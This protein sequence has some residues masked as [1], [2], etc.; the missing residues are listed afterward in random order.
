LI[1]AAV[2]FLLGG[3]RLFFAPPQDRSLSRRHIFRI[4]RISHKSLLKYQ[5]DHYPSSAACSGAGLGNEAGDSFIESR[6]AI[7]L[8][9]GC[10]TPL[11]CE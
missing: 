11:C 4:G 2:L 10:H 1:G 5:N 7:I 3:N 6:C 9:A 8:F